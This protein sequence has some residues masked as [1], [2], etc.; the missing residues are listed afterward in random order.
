MKK[1]KFYRSWIFMIAVFALLIT[2]CEN[3]VTEDVQDPEDPPKEANA[4][5]ALSS[6]IFETATL[7]TGSIPS[8]TGTADI[9]IDRDTLFFVKG[10]KKRI[11][12]L[13]PKGLNGIPLFYVTVKGVDGYYEAEAAK[14]EENDTIAVLY[15]EFDTDEWDLPV[16]F[17]I[18]IVPAGDAKKKITKPVVVEDDKAP[19]NFKPGEYFW[20]WIS[21]TNNGEF[22]LAPMYPQ[23]TRGTVSG[24]CD[25]DG[26]SYY[27]DCIGTASHRE[28]DYETVFMVTLEYLSFDIDDKVFGEMYQYTQNLDAGTTDFCGGNPGYNISNVYNTYS[29]VYS[30]NPGSCS[31]TIQT[32][33]GLTEPIYDSA[34]NY[35]GEAPLPV[36][37]GTGPAAT[38]QFV[39]N[40]F[41]KEIR[42]VEGA[43]VERMYEARSVSGLEWYD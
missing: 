38:Y 31:L 2:A 7:N 13:Y 15:M 23:V 27:S 43:G 4:A 3:D 22:V 24:C 20:E 19:C 40:H 11:K 39:S 28:V 37:A 33:E 41:L 34:G 35:Y 16:T 18:E 5:K 25:T 32:L 12:F 9:K 42:S 36:Y 10:L 30:Y 14:E 1:E 29:G 26:N 6:L 21:T 8:P 17:D